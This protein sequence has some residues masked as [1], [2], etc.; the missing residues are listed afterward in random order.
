MQ[1]PVA[2]PRV[3]VLMPVYDPDPVHFRQ[4]VDSILRQTLPDLELLIVEDPSPRPAAALL[5][6]LSD[7]RIRHLLR[8]HKGTLVDSLNWG[9]AEARAEWIAR[10]DADDICE[11][12]RL[13]KQFA[14]LRDHPEVDVL[15]SQLAIM[16]FDG[17]P[18]GYRSY[19]LEHDAI[20]HG[21]A[22]SNTLAHPSVCFKKHRVMAAG[23]YR[24]FFNEDYELWSRLAGQRVRF[25][26]HPEALVRY[27]LIPK[28]VRGAKVR[29]ALRGTLEVKGLYW[30]DNMDLQA[31]FRMWAEH[32]LLWLPQQ[33][34]LY[35]FLKTQCKARLRPL[36]GT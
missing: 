19:P 12:R 30:R 20:V 2:S 21:M 16:D 1:T 15:G 13:E 26:N 18:H 29:D 5:A 7:P 36:K 9:L 14:Y 33:L 32:V 4:A 24:H 25:A 8:P 6:D 22:R 27:R 11:P 35:L 34:V 10:A 23:G 28:G 17:E 3:S 31:T